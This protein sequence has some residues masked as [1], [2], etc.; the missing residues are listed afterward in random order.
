VCRGQHALDGEERGQVGGVRRD[1]DQ[2]EKP[3]DRAD[4]PPRHRPIQSTCTSRDRPPQPIS[5]ARRQI[6]LNS[7]AANPVKR[8]FKT[9]DDTLC[10]KLTTKVWLWSKVS[11]TR[12][13]TITFMVMVKIS[14]SKVKLGQILQFVYIDLQPARRG[15]HSVL[16]LAYTVLGATS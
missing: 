8:D 4:H 2:C 15:N 6:K 5:A 12:G 11:Q 10:S 1:D 16:T 3:P 7:R 13:Y 9:Y 14:R